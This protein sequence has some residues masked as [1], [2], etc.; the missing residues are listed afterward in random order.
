MK[1]S[2]NY[3]SLAGCDGLLCISGEGREAREDPLMI[4]G[5]RQIYTNKQKDGEM[6]HPFLG[7]F[8]AYG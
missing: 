6:N 8:F 2:G 4:S 5:T 1:L 7:G 3:D